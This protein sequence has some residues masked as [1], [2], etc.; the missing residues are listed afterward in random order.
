MVVM[1]PFAVVLNSV[2]FR[3]FGLHAYADGRHLRA[4]KTAKALGWHMVHAPANL[5]DPASGVGIAIRDN[6]PRVTLLPDTAETLIDGRCLRVKGIIDTKEIKLASIYLS[7]TPA[8]R[9]T[10][11]DILRDSPLGRDQ[12]SLIGGDFNCV[13][14]VEIDTKSDEDKSTYGN[15]HGL[16]WRTAIN[17]MGYI[18]AHR[19]VNGFTCSGF[20]RLSGT[21]HTH[22]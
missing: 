12:D 16:R 22:A 20:T 9:A 1:A 18:D 15:A 2:V 10:Q 11:I 8:E 17:T 7:A 5:A 21:T 6:S 13:E 4:C 3:P 14:D 19:L